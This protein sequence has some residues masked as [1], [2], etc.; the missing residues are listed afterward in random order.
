MPYKQDVMKNET[1]IHRLGRAQMVTGYG[2]NLRVPREEFQKCV[3]RDRRVVIIA[4]KTGKPSTKI[5]LKNGLDGGTRIL[6]NV[7]MQDYLSSCIPRL[8]LKHGWLF[9]HDWL[10]LLL[11]GTTS[12]YYLP[13]GVRARC[14]RSS[15][16][17][18]I[19]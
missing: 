13:T 15:S 6:E 4:V 11:P 10:W 5:V 16:Y 9:P 2:H 14:T 18:S 12:D 19:T 17:R 3:I 1:V 7:I 8:R